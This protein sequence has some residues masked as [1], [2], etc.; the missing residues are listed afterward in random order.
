MTG[1]DDCGLEPGDDGQTRTLWI[2]L[3]LNGVM[4]V[5]EMVAGILAQSTGLIA[6][7]LDML[8]DSSVYLL[9]LRA[10]GKG[11]AAKARAARF[12]GGAQLVLAALAAA[13]VTRRMAWGSEPEHV[14]ML[15][16]GGLAL[17][18]NV[19]CLALLSRH[20]K[21]DVHMRATWICSRS[22]VL[23]NLGVIAGGLLVGATG[24]RFPDLVAGGAIV[25][26]VLHGAVSILR[27]TARE[28]QDTALT[29]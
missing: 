25:A 3:I 14:T 16:M 8:A 15:G 24:S 11:A 4:F 29:D 10:V 2:L 7:S 9:A 27:E 28:R 22:D 17:A 23:A 12:C 6:D 20:R 1:C 21:G 5:A 26:V 13:D 18:V 19:T